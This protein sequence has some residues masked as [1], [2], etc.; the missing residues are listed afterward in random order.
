MKIRIKIIISIWKQRLQKLNQT[1]NAMV[2][3]N[4]MENFADLVWNMQ[5]L[6]VFVFVSVID[7][8]LIWKYSS[9]WIWDQMLN[10]KLEMWGSGWIRR[11]C[12]GADGDGE[13]WSLN[14]Q[15]V[16]SRKV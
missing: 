9:V 4:K 8:T 15:K 10:W 6:S 14:G 13:V 1:I 7:L 11:C 12:N 3:V 5:N 16:E 2:T